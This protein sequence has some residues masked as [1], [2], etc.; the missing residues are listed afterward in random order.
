MLVITRPAQ[1]ARL[2]GAEA[3][4]T[5]L[6]VTAVVGSGTAAQGLAPGQPGLQLLAN[7]LATAAALAAILMA[8]GP[9]SGGHL[10]PVVTL[11]ARLDGEIG[12]SRAGGYVAAQVAG[13]LGG[14]MVANLMFGL[15]AVELSATRR[16]SPGVWLAEAVATYGLVLIVLG[17]SRNGRPAVVPAAVACYVG[18]AV[19]FTA[20][21]AFANPALTL[22]RALTGTFTGIAPGSVG[23]FVVAQLIGGALGATTGRA[24]FPVPA[25][26]AEGAPAEAGRPPPRSARSRPT[27]METT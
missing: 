26:G 20:S 4:G 7:A 12:L 10:N 13:A 6:L 19:F 5:A 16:A 3:V 18:S 11:V 14:V 9:V 17:A 2:A 22:A 15:P 24:L 27:T 8:V 23:P 1:A 25:T 21:T